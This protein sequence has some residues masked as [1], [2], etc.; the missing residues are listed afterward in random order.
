MPL[1]DRAG[2]GGCSHPSAT[3]QQ[4]ARSSGPEPGVSAASPRSLSESCL[5]NSPG[6]ARS[7]SR[8]AGTGTEVTAAPWARSPFPRIRHPEPRSRPNWESGKFSNPDPRRPNRPARRLR[9][10]SMRRRTQPA[11]GSVAARSRIRSSVLEPAEPVRE[12]SLPVCIPERR[13][14]LVSAWK[15]CTLLASWPL[16]DLFS[17][18]LPLRLLVHLF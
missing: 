9:A 15:R 18:D 12:T 11:L 3:G 2:P 14:S 8:A 6:R 4:A 7:S 5:L 17:L 1:S 16:P 10:T 13:G